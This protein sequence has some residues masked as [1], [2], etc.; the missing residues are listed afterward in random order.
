MLGHPQRVNHLHA[1]RMA[2]NT[3]TPYVPF[4]ADEIHAYRTQAGLQL[5]L[6]ELPRN[7]D[8]EDQVHWIE[9][10]EKVN[11]QWV[12]DLWSV[13]ETFRANEDDPEDPEV[14]GLSIKVTDKTWLV[15]NA[16]YQQAS[17]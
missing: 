6:D 9:M 14:F 17:R 1:L 8:R 5:L 11:D 12:K 10:P 16:V 3:K 4:H 13:Y 7:L 15:V 2:R